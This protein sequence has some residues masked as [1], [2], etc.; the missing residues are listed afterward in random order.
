MLTVENHETFLASFQVYL[1]LTICDNVQYFYLAQLCVLLRKRLVSV[2][3]SNYM[4]V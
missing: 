3:P 4:S 2:C 1:L